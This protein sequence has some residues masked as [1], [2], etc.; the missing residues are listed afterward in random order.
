LLY[1]VYHSYYAIFIAVCVSGSFDPWSIPMQGLPPMDP[2]ALPRQELIDKLIESLSTR[3]SIRVTAP[4][5]SGKS[6]IIQLLANRLSHSGA[7]VK[8][9]PCVSL[10]NV[11]STDLRSRLFNLMGITKYEDVANSIIL[12]DDAGRVFQ[13]GLGV[14]M[15]KECPKFGIKI[16]F[17]NAFY[18]TKANG[19]SP[20][21]DVRV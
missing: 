9:V 4:P 7:R 16:A 1:V 3:N 19:V 17:F 14:E 15:I 8:M 6:S 21:V 10:E 2:F 11:S 20:V 18:T 12:L 13:D 5:A